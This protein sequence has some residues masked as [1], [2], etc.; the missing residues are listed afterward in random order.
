MLLFRLTLRLRPGKSLPT[1]LIN[2]YTF[3]LSFVFSILRK[4]MFPE[5][6][7]AVLTTCFLLN[8]YNI[9]TVKLV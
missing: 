8:L 9:A 6:I 7:L 5:A 4:L 3:I 2:S 1:R